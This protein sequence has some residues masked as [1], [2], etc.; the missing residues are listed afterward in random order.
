MIGRAKPSYT[1]TDGLPDGWRM[2][3]HTGR[4]QPV[5]VW[6]GKEVVFF[7]ASADRARQKIAEEIKKEASA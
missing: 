5:T 2:D 1:V 4:K 7:V 6:Q 3:I